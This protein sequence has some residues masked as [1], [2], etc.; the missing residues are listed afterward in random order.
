MPVTK[1]PAGKGQW[2]SGSPNRAKRRPPTDTMRNQSA[3]AR[4]N[5]KIRKDNAYYSNVSDANRT[6]E[7][8]LRDVGHE[9]IRL[10]TAR[11]YPREQYI[12]RL[13]GRVADKAISTATPSAD[14]GIVMTVIFTMAGLILFYRLVT[15]SDQT[16]AFLNKTQ[17]WLR[18]I[19]TNQPLFKVIKKV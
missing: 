8:Q 19:S 17:N 1:G 5:A 6:R 7:L 18:A 15:G 9:Q 13:P 3:R 10:D 14:S 2:T 12:G 11:R 4:A 16:G